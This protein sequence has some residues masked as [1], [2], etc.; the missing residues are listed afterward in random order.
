[1]KTKP[2]R[3]TERPDV[4]WRQLCAIGTDLLRS[5]P[6]I[7]DFEWA[8][9]IKQRLVRLGF[10]YPDPPHRL[11]EA[12]RAVQRALEKSW[13]PRPSPLPPYQ[14][15]STSDRESPQADPPWPKRSGAPQGWTSVQ[16]LASRKQRGAGSQSSSEVVM[17]PT[18]PLTVR[19][20][21]RLKAL[22]IVL[23]AIDDQLDRCDAAERAVETVHEE[24]AS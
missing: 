13:G 16:L 19:D 3:T 21:D 20:A 14:N 9:R 2:E 12:M 23:Q 10:A 5:D 8:E 15:H 18:K 11:T 22:R 4:G 6:T 17:T 7:D 1:M 24:P